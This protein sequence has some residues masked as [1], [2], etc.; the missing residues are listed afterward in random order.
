[1]ATVRAGTVA[2][3]GAHTGPLPDMT[4][5][6]EIWDAGFAALLRTELLGPLSTFTYLN[7]TLQA[8]LGGELDFGVRLYSRRNGYRSSVVERTVVLV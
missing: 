4:F 7:A 5:E 2:A 6:L 1:M 3:G 8:D